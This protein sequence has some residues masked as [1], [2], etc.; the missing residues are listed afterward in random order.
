MKWRS[1]N[2]LRL[3][4]GAS[5][6]VHAVLLGTRW[7]NPAWVERQLTS[8]ALEVIL[9]NAR[10]SERPTRAQAIAQHNMAG[11]GAAE[12]GYASSP[13]AAE[14]ITQTGAAAQDANQRKLQNLQQQQ[15]QLLAQ[16]KQQLANLP[17]LAPQPTE[18]SPAQL[19]QEQQRQQLLK[20]LAQIE[21]RIHTENARPR[22]RYVS[23]A[24]Q[25]AVYALYYDQ[26]R[27]KIETK[28]THNFPVA[29]GQKLYGALTMLITINSDG[30]VLQ[31]EVIAPS[32]N[33]T[34]DRRAQAI[35]Q[36]AAPFGAF[37]AAMRN[38]ADQLLV[39]S[40]FTFNRDETLQTQ[41]VGK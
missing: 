29:N 2:P 13:L 6:L 5:V 9:V 37:N 30:R 14:N 10:T 23:P 20:L 26:L 17:P 4:L 38:Q 7:A 16:I 22:K 34:L 19:A 39:V 11:G 25:E 21:R 12:R 36:S 31:T 3:A 24:T 8:D 28:G 35:V 33:P 18:P 27:I 41:F 15:S 32:G 40:T 1:G